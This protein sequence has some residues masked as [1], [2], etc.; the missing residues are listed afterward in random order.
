MRDASRVGGDGMR[1]KHALLG[2]AP[3]NLFCCA[4]SAGT[5]KQALRHG[6]VD[7]WWRSGLMD[8]MLNIYR[9]ELTRDKPRH[10][11]RDD[12]IVSLS[13]AMELV[14]V[15][16]VLLAEPHGPSD[17]CDRYYQA[18]HDKEQRQLFHIEWPPSLNRL[19]VICML[20]RKPQKMVTI[21]QQAG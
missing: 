19:S 5:A 20:L 17:R 8:A 3:S 16:F 4:L 11:L 10:P 13:V 7:R 6:L 12:G 1:G 14:T 15:L 18:E 21:S 2:Q 9:V